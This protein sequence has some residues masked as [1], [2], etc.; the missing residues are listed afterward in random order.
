M[1]KLDI[2]FLVILE[3]SGSQSE[4]LMNK[5]RDKKFFFTIVDSNSGMFQEPMLS[6]ILGME[7]KSFPDLMNIVEETCQPRNKYIPTQ[8]RVPYSAVGSPM[9]EASIGGA[10]VYSMKVEQFIRL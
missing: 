6:L 5:L 7:Q 3:V 10:N 1:P 4:A 8:M 2:D 9:V